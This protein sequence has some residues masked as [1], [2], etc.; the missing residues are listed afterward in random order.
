MISKTNGP[1]GIKPNTKAMR[2]LNLKEIFKGTE[3]KDVNVQVHGRDKAIFRRD[4]NDIKLI[5]ARTIIR[6]P[7]GRTSGVKHAR[8]SHNGKSTTEADVFISNIK[9]G[10]KHLTF[11][12]ELYG[13]NRSNTLTFKLELPSA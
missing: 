10:K 8:I 4:R 9:L 3:D 6:F 13:S 7:A 5:T 11:T 2:N 1:T 12:A